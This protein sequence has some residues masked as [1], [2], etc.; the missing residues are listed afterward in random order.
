MLWPTLPDPWFLAGLG[1][2]LLAVGA[3]AGMMAGLLGVGGGIVIV[4][5]LFHFFTLLGLEENVCMPMAVGTSLATIIPTTVVSAYVHHQRG[6]VDT[7]LL[8]RWGGYMILGVV[9][10]TYLSS[11]GGWRF[12]TA[13]FSVVS[14]LVAAHMAF[15]TE[16]KTPHP[17]P[18]GRIGSMGLAVLIGCLSVMMGIGGGTL[19]VPVLSAFS[20]PIRQATGTAAA[21]GVVIAVPGAIGFALSGAGIP[22]RPLLTIGYVNLIGFLLIAP[23]TLLTV[24]LGVY[25]AHILK[26]TGLRR[27]FAVFLLLTSYRM[28]AS[29][30]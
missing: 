24:P 16:S 23:V 14:L 15:I 21:L 7:V 26:P 19:S 28:I 30:F 25:L 3:V 27:I 22:G 5:M 20:Y 13:L 10:G 17:R 11:I 12:L 18:P 8:R 2:S 29:L 1:A 6:S 9:V 4:P